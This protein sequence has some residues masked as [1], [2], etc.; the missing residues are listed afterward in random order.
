M[1]SLLHFSL[2]TW[3][4]P[5]LL[6]WSTWMSWAEAGAGLNGEL[7]DSN[8]EFLLLMIWQ[9]LFLVSLHFVWWCPSDGG[10]ELHEHI[11]VKDFFH[12]WYI[13][14]EFWTIIYI[15]WLCIIIMYMSSSHR[16]QCK[17]F[18]VKNRHLPRVMKVF[19]HFARPTLVLKANVLVHKNNYFNLTSHICQLLYN[20]NSSQQHQKH[21]RWKF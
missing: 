12:G 11:I 8:Q 15:F 10:G 21:L 6:E 5:Y 17:L 2:V 7:T 19:K 4:C 13:L 3:Y 14:L 20:L 16:L 1:V 18:G 9:P